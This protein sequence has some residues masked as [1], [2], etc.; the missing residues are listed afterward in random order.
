[1]DT[2]PDIPETASASGLAGTV[3]IQTIRVGKQQLT[4][5]LFNQLPTRRLID[6]GEAKLLG[7]VWGWVAVADPSDRSDGRQYVAQFGSTLCRCPVNLR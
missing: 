2:E 4:L 7:T 6:E 5:A 1:M 3:A